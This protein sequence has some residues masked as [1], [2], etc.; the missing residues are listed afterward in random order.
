MRKAFKEMLS[1]VSPWK[2]RKGGA[3]HFILTQFCPSKNKSSFLHCIF[4]YRAI[5]SQEKAAMLHKS[6]NK[7]N[8]NLSWDVRSPQIIW[9]VVR[10]PVGW[11]RSSW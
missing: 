11:L 10:S 5:K 6:T 3:L 1:S 7:A 8:R 2:M 9:K 4:I